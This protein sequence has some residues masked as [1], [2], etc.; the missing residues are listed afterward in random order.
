MIKIVDEAAKNVE[1]PPK[2]TLSNEPQPKSFDAPI[3][4]ES[5]TPTFNTNIPLQGLNPIPNDGSHANFQEEN[6]EK[7]DSY[8]Q[9]EF[10]EVFVEIHLDYDQKNPPITSGPKIIHNIK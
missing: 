9:S 2:Q 10:E 5:S 8:A 4:G 1:I 3:R 6:N 7:N